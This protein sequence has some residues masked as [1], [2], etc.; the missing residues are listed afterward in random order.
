MFLRSPGPHLQITGE[1]KNCYIRS[2]SV[3]LYSVAIQAVPRFYSMLRNLL[4][5]A[6]ILNLHCRNSVGT[7]AESDAS[8]LDDSG[9]RLQEWQSNNSSLHMTNGQH[10]KVDTLAFT[11]SRKKKKREARQEGRRTCSSGNQGTRAL[12]G[13][14]S[15]MLTSI[16]QVSHARMHGLVWLHGNRRK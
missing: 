14:D 4:V 2:D 7:L 3:A 15:E 10:N 9:G 6:V 8:G 12:Q 1:C 16:T 11:E 5:A 13:A